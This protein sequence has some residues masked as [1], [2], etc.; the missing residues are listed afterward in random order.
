MYSQELPDKCGSCQH[1]RSALYLKQACYHFDGDMTAFPARTQKK[2]YPKIWRHWGVLKSH[3]TKDGRRN[4]NKV[5]SLFHS[6][7][8]FSEINHKTARQICTYIMNDIGYFLPYLGSKLLHNGEG[9]EIPSTPLAQKPWHRVKIL[10]ASR[11]KWSECH[12]EKFI[13]PGDIT[14]NLCTPANGYEKHDP[15]PKGIVVG[16]LSTLW[17]SHSNTLHQLTFSPTA[18]EEHFTFSLWKSL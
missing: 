11:L 4:E 2:T 7:C 16:F 3:V 15:Q 13:R 18:K 17:T 12:G 10:S 5:A 6:Y 8:P 1:L 14:R 9:A